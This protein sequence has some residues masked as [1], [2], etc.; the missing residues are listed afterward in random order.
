MKRLLTSLLILVG[1]LAATPLWAQAPRSLNGTITAASTDCSVAGSCVIFLK[2][3]DEGAV[4]LQITNTFVASLVFEATNNTPADTAATWY[5]LTQTGMI[6]S[7]SPGTA[8]TG[9][10]TFAGTGLTAVRVRAATYT[11]GTASI[12]FQ[13]G[14]PAPVNPDGTLSVCTG[15]NYDSGILEVPSARTTL[16]ATTIC[17][18]S[19]WFVNTTASPITV[20]VWDGN[21]KLYVYQVVR[22]YSAPAVLPFNNVQFSGGLQWSASSS[23]LNAQVK[24]QQ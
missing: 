14:A 10:W 22:A 24:A 23:G 20:Q 12:A 6:K 17:V 16:V 8:T 2:R 7:G 1:L 18:N 11:S 15:Q 4:T 19:L 21:A 3:T 13:A 5:P 9:T